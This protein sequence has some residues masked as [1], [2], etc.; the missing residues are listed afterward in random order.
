MSLFRGKPYS[1][2][3]AAL[4]LAAAIF[5]WAAGC[6]TVT[7]SPVETWEVKRGE[8]VN[9]LTVTGQL[10]AV[11]SEV[12]FSPEMGWRIGI[13]KIAQIVEDGKQVEKGEVLVQFDQTEVLKTISDAKAELEIARA[14]LTKT[15]VSHQSELSDLEADLKVA[16]INNNISRLKL[17]QAAFEAEIERK[18]I[19]LDL[20][21]SGIN[22]QQA[23]QN[24]ESRK[25]IQKEE[26]SKLGLQVRQAELK[27][28]KAEQTLESLTIKA[29]SPGIAIIRESWMTRNKFQVDDQAWPGW[30]LIGLPDL[31]RMK[32][33]VEI[34]EV[35]ISQIEI[36]QKA[37]IRLDAFPEASF[38]GQ[39]S[40]IATLARNKN[41]DSKVKVFDAI[42]LIDGSD[43][44]LMPGM[45]VSCE[46]T[47]GQLPDT[48]FIPLD[49][50]FFKE[51]RG[52]VY[53]KNGSGFEPR[54][55]QT[56]EESENYVVIAG[57][58]KEG[59]LVALRDPTITPEKEEKKSENAQESEQ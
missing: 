48:L 15:Q 3:L 55:V 41:R 43:D 32:A 1:G 28:Q 30:P 25:K 36:G 13:P 21:Q 18:K 42:I 51:G 46:I 38:N 54:E 22:L 49:A 17:E 56:G 6:G 5:F 8:F 27:L 19:E 26:I 59:D 53:L 24:I 40:E 7:G 47:V 44:R 58:L 20:K 45:T 33:E 2:S 12:I 31:S 4:G 10:D 29:P 34:N 9:S 50:L 35:E 14:E 52:I 37:T 11:N 23:S 57:G 16:A 39:I